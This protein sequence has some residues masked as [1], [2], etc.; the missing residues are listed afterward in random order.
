[1]VGETEEHDP[2]T[3]GAARISPLFLLVE[4][5]VGDDVVAIV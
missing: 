5:D 3:V 2:S 4:N 1:M